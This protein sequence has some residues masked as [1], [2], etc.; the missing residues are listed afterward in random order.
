MKKKCP[1][2][3]K[4]K[5]GYGFVSLSSGA[6]SSSEVCASC[7]CRHVAKQNGERVPEAIDFDGFEVEDSL[8]KKHYFHVIP[9]FFVGVGMEA[10]EFLDSGNVGYHFSVVECPGTSTVS[11][12]R[13][14]RGKVQKSLA[15][16]YLKSTNWEHCGNRVD[17]RGSAINGRI[18]ESCGKDTSYS[19]AAIVDGKEYTW[20]EIGEFLRSYTGFHFRIEIYDKF[21]KMPL[22]VDPMKERPSSVPWLKHFDDDDESSVPVQ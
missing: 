1:K 13:L 8:G 4:I 19:A 17:V 14:L 6:E 21:E 3:K 18:V 7:F 9:N 22:S 2:C 20:D 16:S 12:Y 15:V 11:V 5:V 10:V